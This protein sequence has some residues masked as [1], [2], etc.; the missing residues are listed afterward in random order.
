METSENGCQKCV[1]VYQGATL[2][3]R[4]VRFEKILKRKLYK[5]STIL[6][7]KKIN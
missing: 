1:F 2:K 5:I 3:N 7:P 6:F 4:I